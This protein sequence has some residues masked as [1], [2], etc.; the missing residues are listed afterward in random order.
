MFTL[1]GNLVKK[2]KCLITNEKRMEGRNLIEK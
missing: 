2:I 1:D